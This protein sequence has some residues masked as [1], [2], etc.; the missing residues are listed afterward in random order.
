MGIRI[1]LFGVPRQ[2]AGVAETTAEGSRL[3]DVL[4]DLALRFP[5]LAKTCFD[6]G[7]LRAGYLASIDGER[8]VTDPA[9]AVGP[10]DALL[11]L[12]ADSGG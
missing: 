1:E 2:R 9:T 3:D 11:I 6:A 10:G 8:F 5:D 4:A 7:R 12:S